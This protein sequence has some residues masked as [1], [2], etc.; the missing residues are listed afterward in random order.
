MLEHWGRSVR[1]S[2]VRGVPVS[3]SEHLR[4]RKRGE[5]ASGQGWHLEKQ[6]EVSSSLRMNGMALEGLEGIYR[7]LRALEGFFFVHGGLGA[8]APLSGGARRARHTTRSA[9]RRGHGAQ[10]IGRGVGCAAWDARRMGHAARAC[11]GA[12]R[13]LS[14]AA[15]GL[16]C[17]VGRRGCARGARPVLS[18]SCGPLN[19]ILAT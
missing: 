8:R 4:T 19:T 2:N 12:A 10:V 7:C 11:L 9:R 1:G 14:G 6:R 15:R 16:L 18:G 5:S 3:A 13:G 17:L